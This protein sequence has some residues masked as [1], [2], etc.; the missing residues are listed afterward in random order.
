[1]YHPFDFLIWLPWKKLSTSLC[2]ILSHM[3]S[4][5][6]TDWV[7]GLFVD[8]QLSLHNFKYFFL[9]NFYFLL[10][11]FYNIT[12]FKCRLVIKINS[13]YRKW[14]IYRD[15]VRYRRPIL[16]LAHILIIAE[17]SGH[18]FVDF[19]KNDVSFHSKNGSG[20]ISVYR[21]Q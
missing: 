7:Y 17:F 3:L 5:D 10:F 12:Y 8:I 1:M 14:A 21:Y 9:Y 15:W 11:G 18:Y 6:W 13:W 2:Q 20:Q 4:I 16:V 19:K